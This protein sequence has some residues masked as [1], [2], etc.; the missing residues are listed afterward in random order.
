MLQIEIRSKTLNYSKYVCVT[1]LVD[2]ITFSTI[3]LGVRHALI[4]SKNSN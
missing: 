1:I 3:I 2:V 4:V